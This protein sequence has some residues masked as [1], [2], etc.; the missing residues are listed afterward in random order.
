MDGDL[1]RFKQVASVADA[2]ATASSRAR[3]APR[4]APWLLIVFATFL[5][6]IL[7]WFNLINDG[8]RGALDPRN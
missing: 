2:I 1:R 4:Q 3:T 8:L 5:R 7:A 6:A